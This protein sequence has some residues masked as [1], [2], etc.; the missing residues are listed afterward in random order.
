MAAEERGEGHFVLGSELVLPTDTAE[1][2]GQV[3]DCP[4]LR[5]LF[6]KLEGNGRAELTEWLEKGN[7][8]NLCKTF[9]AMSGTWQ[10][11]AGLALLL[12]SSSLSL[13]LFSLNNQDPS[14]GVPDFPL[15]L[16]QCS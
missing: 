11:L 7:E 15:T 6:G 14:P 10:T 12:L 13:L 3:T 16:W 8:F 9:Q 5:L 2:L 4:H 1:G